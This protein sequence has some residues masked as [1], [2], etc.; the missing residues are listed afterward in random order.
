MAPTSQAQRAG[1]PLTHELKSVTMK[2]RAWVKVSQVRTP[3]TRRLGRK[4]ARVAP[5]DD[6]ALRIGPFAGGRVHTLS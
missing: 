6:T 4:I 1:F 2:E 5:A 3:S